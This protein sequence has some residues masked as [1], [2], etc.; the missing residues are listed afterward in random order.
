[1]TGTVESDGVTIRYATSGSGRPLVLL[2][3]FTDSSESWA[4]LGY[5]EPLAAAGQRLI[6]IDQRG[7]G[8]SDGPHEIDASAADARV[9]DVAAVLDELGVERAAILG[10]SMGGWVALNLA[11]SYPERIDRMIVGGA[12]PL[13]QSMAL[14]REAVATDIERWIDVL[15]K[16]GGPLPAAQKARIRANDIVALRAAVAEDRP[17]FADRIVEFDRPS[18]FYVGAEDPLRAAIARCARALPRGRYCEILGCNHVTA[19]LRV[20]LVLPVLLDFLSR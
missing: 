19:L 1:M 4:E 6:L 20:D 13:G 8:A 7:H 5:V 3:G 11:R 12:H 17:D 15:E 2:H 18:L 10:Y 9:R 16:L 14:Y